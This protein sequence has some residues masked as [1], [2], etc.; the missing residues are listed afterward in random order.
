MD[1]IYHPVF[2][3]KYDV[4]ET[5]LSRLQV[6]P[7]QVCPTEIGNLYLRRH[8]KTKILVESSFE[9]SSFK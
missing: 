8:P 5:A 4:S 3:L 7:T 9:T 2:Y 1:I 6:E